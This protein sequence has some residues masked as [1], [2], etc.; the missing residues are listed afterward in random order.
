[1]GKIAIDHVTRRFN[2]SSAGGWIFS[3]PPLYA[4]SGSIVLTTSLN[5]N[6][7]KNMT[8][9]PGRNLNIATFF[10]LLA[11]LAGTANAQMVPPPTCPSKD[12]SKVITFY[13]NNP[14]G[15]GVMIFP[16]IQ[17]GIQNPDPWLQALF[18]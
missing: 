16:V 14:I 8:T 13:N 12:C 4:I 17:A 2:A 11:S 10:L 7:D 3:G 6:E 5:K 18:N 9:P 1:A 15:S